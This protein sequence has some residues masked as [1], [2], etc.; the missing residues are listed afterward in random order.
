MPGK[1]NHAHD[2]QYTYNEVNRDEQIDSLLIS[3][4][5]AVVLSRFNAVY[6]VIPSTTVGNGRFAL[7]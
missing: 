7:V 2:Q 4:A 3:H 6:A 5:L 1:R